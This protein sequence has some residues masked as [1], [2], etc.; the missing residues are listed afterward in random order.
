MTQSFALLLRLLKADWDPQARD[1]IAIAPDADWADVVRLAL[2]HGVAGLLCRSLGRVPAGRVPPDIAEAAEVF[3]EDAEAEGTARVAQLFAIL[4][5]LAADRIPVMPYKGAALGELAHA[6]PTLRP[7][8]DIDVLVHKEDMG[9]AVAS[10]CRSGYH[11]GE[12]FS[13]RVM[14]ACFASYGQEILFADGRL[15]VEPHWTFGP[16]TLAIE[17][18]LD[19]LWARARPL[20]IAGRPT[21]ALSPEDMLFTAC[22]HGGKEKWWRLLWVADVAGLIHRHRALDW[23]ALAQRAE[24]SGTTRLLLLGLALAEE[25][26]ACPL[27]RALSDAIAQ[28]PACAQLATASKAW[29]VACDGNV[30]SVRHVSSYHLRSK[31]RVADRIRYV[32]RTIT[33]PNV[34]HYRMVQLPDALLHGYVPLKLAHDYVALPLWRLRQ[35]SPFRRKPATVPDP[36]R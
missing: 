6:S 11:L 16:S 25:L 3:L 19:G 15:P 4:D 20:A 36:A 9:V 29:M 24:A 35:A 26:F 1:A 34:T 22:L 12:V 28:D 18:D 23:T 8:R 2:H 33:T 14:L 30:G 10:L 7:S 31:E 13:P 5:A 17:L 32:W 21:L 27:P